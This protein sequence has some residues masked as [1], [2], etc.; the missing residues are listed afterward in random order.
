MSSPSSDSSSSDEDFSQDPEIRA[1][2][3]MSESLARESQSSESE[4]SGDEFK[5]GLTRTAQA[6]RRHLFQLQRVSF[7]YINKKC[8][9]LKLYVCLSFFSD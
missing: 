7:L 6:N 5:P 3:A 9:N 4:D 2:K 1:F 8:F